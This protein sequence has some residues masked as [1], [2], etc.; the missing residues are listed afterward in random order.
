METGYEDRGELTRSAAGAA[1]FSSI[2]FG[3]AGL[4]SFALAL[5]PPLLGFDDTDNPAVSIAFVR[6]HPDVHVFAGIALIVMAIALTVAILGVAEVLSPR[7]DSLAV[8]SLSALGLFAAALF[9]VTGGLQI[10]A[11][12]PLLHI[13]SL[14]DEWGEAAYLA[15]Q[16]AGQ[17]V[18]ISGIVGLCLWAVGLS[19]I[20]RRRRV[21]ATWLFFLG[22]VPAFRLVVSTLGPLGLLP[23]FELLWI[24]G[25]V[26]IPGTMVWCFLLGIVLLR[27][28]FGPTRE[29]LA[30]PVTAGA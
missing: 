16:V 19:V 25:M 15:A 18:G 22:I 6:A 28:G 7:A 14:R 4:A 29:D 10:G 2:V 8:R 24:L 20:G 5:V 30:V 17:A 12:G 23:D 11:S 9:L 26:S 27:R 1:G 3:L 13:A 21:L